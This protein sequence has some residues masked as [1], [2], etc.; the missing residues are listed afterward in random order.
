M[1]PAT[2][3]ALAASR[4]AL[5]PLQA[6]P[7]ALRSLVQ[8]L[9]V[10]EHVRQ[11]ENPELTL[12]GILPTMVLLGQESS[13]NVMASIW[14]GFEG[15]LETSIPR[16]DVFTKA[17]ELGLPIGFLGG[18]RPPEARRFE[19]LADELDLRITELTGMTGEEDEN[20]QR[21]LV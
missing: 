6:E 1:G 16:A 8:T 2:R 3:A 9:R 13:L 10:I 17:S 18:R 21:K 12:L 4:F 7:M 11:H 20:A 5:V 14:S 15:V 19:V